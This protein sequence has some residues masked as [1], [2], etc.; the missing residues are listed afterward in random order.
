MI[1]NTDPQELKVQRI[2]DYEMF[3]PT[4]G[5]HIIL[6]FKGSETMADEG[7]SKTIRASENR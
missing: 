4:W 3:S 6:F 5:I 7:K 1:I 2:R